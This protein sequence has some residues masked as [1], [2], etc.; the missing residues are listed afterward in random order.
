MAFSAHLLVD[1][2]EGESADAGYDKHIDVMS[3]SVGVSNP[4]NTLGGGF[5]AGKATA[6][7]FHFMLAQGRSSVNLEKFCASGTHIKTVTL[8]L[9]KSIGQDAGLKEFMTVTFTDCFI[10]S[11]QESGGGD[12]PMDSIGITYSQKKV[13]YKEQK[14]AG[15]ALEN[16]ASY[17]WDFKANAAA[18]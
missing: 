8:K 18:A 5:S 14:T 6:S 9:S 4:P 3:Y 11:S 15:G 2:I 13:E 1:Q 12:V 16:A 7:E 17:G 10:S